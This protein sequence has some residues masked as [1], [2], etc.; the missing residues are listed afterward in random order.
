MIRE[1]EQEEDDQDRD[2]HDDLQPLSRALLALVPPAPPDE[3]AGRQR[4]TGGDGRLGF[5]DE[6]A[7]IPVLHVEQHRGQ[8]EPVLGVDHRG[9][10]RLFDVDHLRERQ[11]LAGR[12]GNQ[13]VAECVRVVTEL[14]RVTHPHRKSTTTLEGEREAPL[15]D[16]GAD[17]VLY[18]GDAEPVPGR[19]GAI[20][21]HVQVLRA[22]QRL[23]I[24]VAGAANGAQHRGHAPGR[25]VQHFQITA[26]DLHAH[27]GSD[28]GRQHVDSVD[29]RHRPDVRDAGEL[30]R[31]SQLAAQPLQR[32]P[33][34]PLLARLEVHDRLGH[35]E[36]RR[37]G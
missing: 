37:I 19:A 21:A 34:P 30:R 36:R 22:G 4:D 26:I 28:A 35:V 10:A 25:L 33:A 12:R 23:R 6:P 11:L 24:D 16:G 5:F 2:R 15:A 8:Q 14:G 27:F 13:H 3:V 18:C 7:E 31:T 1:V 20:D 9:A 17:H 32:H 29:D